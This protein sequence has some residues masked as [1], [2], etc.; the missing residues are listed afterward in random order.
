MPLRRTPPA[1]AMAMAVAMPCFMSLC[2][3]A[4]IQWFRGRAY[5]L[6]RNYRQIRVRLRDRDPADF[7]VALASRLTNDGRQRSV[8]HCLGEEFMTIS[9]RTS[10]LVH[11]AAPRVHGGVGL[12]C[13]RRPMRCGRRRPGRGRQQGQEGADAAIL[14]RPSLRRHDHQ[15]LSRARRILRHGG[16][17]PRRGVRR[18]R[19]RRVRSTTAS[20]A[21]TISS[22]CR[23]FPSR[24]CCPRW[25]APNRPA[26]R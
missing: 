10:V 19:C 4:A 20:R 21:N 2:S 23:R 15:E 12:C 16:N 24:G 11:P 17:D 22:W 6:A 5:R 25:C 8:S 1:K 14:C 18:A 26:F 3:R 13:P 9:A 7:C